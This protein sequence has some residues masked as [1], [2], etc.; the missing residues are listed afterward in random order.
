MKTMDNKI[1]EINQHISDALGE[2]AHILCTSDADGWGVHLDYSSEDMLNAIIIF[3]SVMSNVAI[4][5]GV[6]DESNAH[7]VGEKIKR[8][9]K[10]TFG[11]DT[12][13]LTKKVFNE[14]Y[15]KR[16]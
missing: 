3:N 16:K 5:K 2:W 14:E 13:K 12:I 1:K 10:E 15:G 4:K 6:I 11:V 7:E 8:F 9:V